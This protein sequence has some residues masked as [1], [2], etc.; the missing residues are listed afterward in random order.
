[1]KFINTLLAYWFNLHQGIRYFLVGC[2]NTAVG[3]ILF[4]LFYLLLKTL[5]NYH[6]ILFLSYCVSLC[7]AYLCM[8][9]LVF[10]SKGNFKKEIPKYLTTYGSLYVINAILLSI[11]VAHLHLPVLL[12]QLIATAIVALI[13]YFANKCFSFKH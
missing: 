7:N 2:S 11:L 8:K 1:M 13:G 4:V 9:F 3:Y 6:V 5:L 12:G 10:Q